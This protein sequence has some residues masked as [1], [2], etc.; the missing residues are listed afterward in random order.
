MRKR[1][2]VGKLRFAYF[3]HASLT[4]R[5]YLRYLRARLVWVMGPGIYHPPP[6]REK[7]AEMRGARAAP[8]TRVACGFKVGCWDKK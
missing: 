8:A 1:R 3:F 4:L 7:G 2:H 5:I 6:R